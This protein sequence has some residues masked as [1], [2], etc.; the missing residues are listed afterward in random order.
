MHEE[1]ANWVMDPSNNAG[2]ASTY[3][4]M[5]MTYWVTMR[6]VGHSSVVRE[7][8]GDGDTEPVHF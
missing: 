6:M 1:V 8:K 5:L 2:R 3:D 4:H 7:A